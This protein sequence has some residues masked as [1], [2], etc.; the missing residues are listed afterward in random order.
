[1]WSVFQTHDK[2]TEFQ[3]LNF[4]DHP[5]IAPEHTKFLACNSR[6]LDMLESLKKDVATVK[7]ELKES[8]QRLTQASKK[9]NVTSTLVDFNKKSLGELTRQVDKKMDK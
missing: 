1:M 6:F 2:M 4:E 8:G 9:A 7:A 3:D 5:A